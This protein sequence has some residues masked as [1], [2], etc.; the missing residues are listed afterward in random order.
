MRGALAYPIILAS[1]GL[2]TIGLLV[3]VVVPKFAAILADLGQEL[4]ATTRLVLA[5]SEWSRTLTMPALVALGVVLLA[6]RAWIAQDAG[7]R[8]W[9]TWLLALP[10]AGRIRRSS[11]ASRAGAA[12]GALLESGVPLPAALGYAARASGDAALGARLGT[13]R[14]RIAHGER[15]SDAVDREDALTPTAVR[16]I[17][18][19]EETGR[20]ATMLHH[21]AHIESERATQAVK[22]AVRLL[23]PAL[24]LAFGALV[25]LVAAALMQAVYSVR[26]V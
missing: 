1:A 11:A 2:A 17:R 10:I 25:A 26:P 6:G 16:L 19:G 24:I 9:H 12:L 8:R 23:E 21:V 4:P 13:V 18:A 5:G 20:L 15:L 14:E 7:R 3:N 22:N